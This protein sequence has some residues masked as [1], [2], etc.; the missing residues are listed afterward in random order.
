[1]SGA[2]RNIETMLAIFA[3]IEERKA[4][5]AD[6]EQELQLVQP[7]VEF[8]WPPSLPYGGVHGLTPAARSW[9][10]T[11]DPLQ[12]TEA[13]RK[14][15]ARVIAASENE[16]VI[17]WHQRGVASSGERLDVEVLGLY[18][19][20]DAKLARAQMFY[21]DGVAVKDF[22]ARSGPGRSPVNRHSEAA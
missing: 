12:P 17:L 11:W 19:L 2:Q 15:D 14:L 16:V 3:S 22:L 20:N 13:E 21:F 8:H 4:R 10:D 9:S 5:Q 18:Q 7:D 6:F 1:M